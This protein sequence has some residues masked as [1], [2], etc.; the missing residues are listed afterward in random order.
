MT[1]NVYVIGNLCP[2]ISYWWTKD[3]GT[4]TQLEAET[5]SNTLV[6]GGP[7]YCN[8]LAIFDGP[9]VRLSVRMVRVV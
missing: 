8:R 9:F 1:C 6:G 4:L 5:K 7:G 3:N 2:L